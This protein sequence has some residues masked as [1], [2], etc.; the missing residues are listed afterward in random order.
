LLQVLD[1][2]RLTDGQ[3]RVV[4]FSNTLIILTSNLGS[5]YLAN[6]PDGEDVE[7]VREQVMD[8]V[9]G[10]FRPEFLNRLD[11]TL[12]FRRLGRDHMAGIV[13]IQLERLRALLDDRQITLDLDQAAIDWLAK[14]GYD[15]VYGARPL[16]RI[17]QKNLQ[18]PLATRILEGR[19]NDG[20]TVKVTAS[21]LGLFIG[22][23]PAS[24]ERASA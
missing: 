1:D 9:R 5:D 19:I 7:A 6:Q 18:D 14:A 22:D 24:A 21:D 8:V 4:D 10:A 11:E 16:K 20:E 15:P 12:L 23:Q 2:G 13:T 17:I 3:G